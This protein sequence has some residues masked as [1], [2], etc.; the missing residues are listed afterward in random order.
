M[1]VNILKT[2][3]ISIIIVWA[4]INL[5]GF[6][7]RGLF[8]KLELEKLKKEGTE[9]VKKE[10]KK[11]ERAD[12]LMNI[13]GLILLFI[14]FYLLVRYFNLAV[15]FA[16]LLVMVSR[17]QD[18]VWEIKHGKN[19]SSTERNQIPK[20]TVYHITSILSW[21]SMALLF[22]FIYQFYK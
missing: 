10:L 18:L 7:V 4:S 21:V 8:K 3:V 22:Y 5:L 1:I 17:L 6:L 15:L 2:L 13:I 9:F 19:L 20:N 14:Y 12:K 16:V 11:H